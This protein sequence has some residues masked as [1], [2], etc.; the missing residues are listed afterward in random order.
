MNKWIKRILYLL[1][2]GLL[3]FGLLGWYALE[4]VLPYMVIK[5]HRN[6]EETWAFKLPNGNLP[7]GYGLVSTPLDIRTKDGITL[8][9]FYLTSQTEA[10][11]KTTLIMVHGIHGCK[12]H[13]IPHAKR[14]VDA[15]INVALFDLRA[16]GA[17]GGEYCTF[18][19]LEKEDIKTLVDTL[20]NRYPD[21]TIGIFGNSLGGAITLQALAHDKRLEFGLIESTFHDLEEVVA[22]YGEDIFGVKSMWLADQTLTRAGAIAYFPALE[23]KPYQAAQK[24]TQ[25]VFIAHGDADTSIPLEFGRKNYENLGSKEKE[26]YTIHGA[27]HHFIWQSGGEEYIQ[28]MIGFIKKHGGTS[29]EAISENETG[30]H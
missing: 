13:F 11:S 1:G 21:Q 19:Y 7:E 17:S 28:A 10:P 15:G 8:D 5:P 16:H 25:P 18:G 23:V 27:N 20:K 9:G 3:G 12:E 26:W 14:F 29:D 2:F 30:S 22:E 4:N 6:T 24:I